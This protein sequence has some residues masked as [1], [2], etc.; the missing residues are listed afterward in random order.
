MQVMRYK[1]SKENGFSLIELLIVVAIIGILIG[2]VVPTYQN[3][4]K[5]ANEASAVATL[6]T[7]S[8]EQA[9]YATSHRGEYGTFKQLTDAG[10]LDERFADEEPVVSGYIFK[11]TVTPKSKNNPSSYSVNADPQAKGGLNATGNRHFYIDPS[12]S[13]IRSN[14]EQP[15]AATDPPI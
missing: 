12:V 10:L 14:D 6:K 5:T 3:S 15:A 13:T 4:V 1:R 9:K 11:M 8:T 7:I 2:V